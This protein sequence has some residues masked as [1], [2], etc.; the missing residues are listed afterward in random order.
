[1]RHKKAQPAGVNCPHCGSSETVKR[2]RPLERKHGIVQGCKCNGCDKEFAL[3]HKKAQPAGVNCPCC[4]SSETIKVGKS[5]ERKHGIVQRCKCNKCD[6]IFS[7]GHKKAEPAGVN[8]PYCESSETIKVGKSLERKHG[9]YQLCECRECGNRF[10]PSPRKRLQLFSKGKLVDAFFDPPG[11]QVTNNV[12]C[13][14]CDQKKAILK[15]KS[16]DKTK[17]KKVNR[18]ICLGCT[19]KFKGERG[20][21]NSQT[22]RT[23][24]KEVPLES[25]NFEKDRWDLR[26]LY[27]A[28]KE[29]KL[30]QIIMDFTI[31]GSNWFINLHKDYTLWR[32]NLGIK[33]STLRNDFYSLANF[34]RFLEKQRVNSMEKIDR[35]LLEIYYNQEIYNL[36]NSAFRK[37][38]S[39]LST[40]FN[41]GNETQNF[42]TPP[43]LITSFDYPKT[44][45]GEPDPLESS[46][47]EA[48]I[49]NLH[50]LPEP[51][52]L[53]FM[54]GFHLGTRPSELCYLDKKC[55]KPDEDNTIWWVEFEREKSLDKH[56]LPVPTEIVR[57]IKK[58]QTYI[59]K[60]FG[61]D[62]PYLFCHYQE[63]GITDYPNYPRMKAME[64][65]P[66]IPAFSN[67]MVRVIRS[68][69]EKCNILDSNG[70]LANFTGAILRPSRATE[71]INTGYSLHFVRKWLKHRR[72][73]TTR[74]HY[75]RYDPGQL[76]DVGSVMANL[77]QK[78]YPYDSNPESLNPESLRQNP[79]LHELDGLTMLNGEPLYG[80]CSFREFCPYD[81]GRCYT[82]GSHI[83]SADKLSHY[84]SQL[85][86]LKT[87]EQLASNYGSSEILESYQ[88]LV[89]ALESIIDAL[90]GADEQ[91]KE[92][93]DSPELG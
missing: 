55:L 21:W 3:G 19:Q 39:R 12:T 67:P 64:H 13:P 54:L 57:L 40:F 70:K 51:L 65:P 48:I 11:L 88:Q 66:I 18:Y 27:P 8:C 2:R 16:Y 36:K 5:L 71:L 75:T 68:L 44:F 84:K 77:G 89:N 14:N 72:K 1:M 63:L 35:I 83:A 4:E 87:K 93:T 10:N 61:D 52:Q 6:K 22:R 62:Y 79:E 90:E 78:F 28:I 25:W 17:C 86:R 80:Y 82:C 45:S 69:I 50:I 58:Q 32:I 37:Q 46:V 91:G 74:L 60:L 49:N 73:S 34:G 92:A 81:F 20:A 9:I 15:T 56:R 76:L 29:Y 47:I 38:I 42:I 7:S 43:G 33:P 53:M 26:V 85:E 59:N 24:G 23:L 41:Y 30:R 31:S